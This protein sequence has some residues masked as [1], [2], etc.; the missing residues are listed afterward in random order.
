[1]KMMKKILELG[2]EYK[3][4]VQASLERF[5]KC[6]IGI[7]DSCAINGHHICKDGPVFDDKKLRK[8][9]DF[10]KFKRDASGRKVKI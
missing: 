2:L 5:M 9:K 3:I 8:M 1:E 4:S 6:G 7:C 10:G